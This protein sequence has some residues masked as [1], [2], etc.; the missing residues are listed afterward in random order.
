MFHVKHS[1]T[2]LYIFI[3][4]KPLNLLLQQNYKLRKDA[5]RK[6]TLFKLTTVEQ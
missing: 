5:M 6:K 3:A 2:F 1:A 4:T